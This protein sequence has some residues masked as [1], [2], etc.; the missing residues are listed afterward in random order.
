MFEALKAKLAA[1]EAARIKRDQ[2]TSI[3]HDMVGDSGYEA[4]RTVLDQALGNRTPTPDAS[5]VQLCQDP[6]AP[7]LAQ[8]QVRLRNPLRGI[9]VE[10]RDN[11]FI[12]HIQDLA[13]RLG[14]NPYA[15]PS[16]LGAYSSAVRDAAE[17]I[18]VHDAL[19]ADMQQDF[20]ALVAQR[21]CYFQQIEK[22]HIRYQAS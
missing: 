9:G 13:E 5:L 12:A 7:V 16:G 6:A 2:A 19:E 3:Q 20:R 10:G 21:M 14:D 15:L 22:K 1:R 8:H 11:H 17:V 4:L 18:R